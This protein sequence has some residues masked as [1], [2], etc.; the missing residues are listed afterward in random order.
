MC[1]IL[2]GDKLI[3]LNARTGVRDIYKSF[4]NSTSRTRVQENQLNTP[5]FA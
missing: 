5:F 1:I 2:Q 4:N 3:K